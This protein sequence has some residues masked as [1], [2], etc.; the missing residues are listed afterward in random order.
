MLRL[1]A[2]T[3][4]GSLLSICPALSQEVDS[5]SIEVRSLLESSTH[6]SSLTS[7]VNSL[8]VNTNPAVIQRIIA[9]TALQGDTLHARFPE[10]LERNL[11]ELVPFRSYVQ[12]IRGDSV[13]TVSVAE[14]WSL[15][16]ELLHQR[17]N[18]LELLILKEHNLIGT[19][20]SISLGS[21]IDPVSSGSRR[22]LA[23]FS[24]PELFNTPL[25]LSTTV[26]GSQDQLSIRLS[27]Q[28][29]FHS[30]FV[31][32]VYGLNGMVRDGDG[33]YYSGDPGRRTGEF[34]ADTLQESQLD[35]VGWIGTG[36]TTDDLFVGGGAVHINQHSSNSRSPRERAFA[37]TIGLFAG[38]Q[39]LRREY[40]LFEDF[41]GRG[42]R[43]EPSG[44]MGRVSIGKFISAGGGNDDLLYLGAGAAQSIGGA[45][46]FVHFRIDAGTALRDKETELTLLRG[47]SSGG[48]RLGPGLLAY[49]AEVEVVWR[50]QRYLF[51]PAADSDIPFRG[52]S[53]LDVFGDNHLAASFEYRILPGFELGPWEVSGTLFH[54]VAGYWNLGNDF[55]K[56]V[57]HH[58]LGAGIRLGHADGPARPLF[59][60]DFPYNVDQGRFTG[61]ALGMSEAFD[62][63]GSLEYAPPG[64]V[65]PD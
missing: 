5:T 6:S 61:V 38:I 36:S 32:I 24:D 59:R 64:P 62:L 22:Y 23:G 60:I 19:A 34:T 29:P 33:V 26:V 40:D 57:F 4:V 52:Y 42:D 51:S 45:R 49:S 65:L 41:D 16:P 30:D 43:F 50:W 9:R 27:L 13:I 1:V 10:E 12:E 2:L 18:P 47:G 31:P 53:D 3:V 48:F 54:D 44:G 17:G 15:L 35:V 20:K 28:R 39:S 21:D 14:S 25:R 11:R 63:F 55:S 56:T 58:A 8:H 37:N 46:S 7:L